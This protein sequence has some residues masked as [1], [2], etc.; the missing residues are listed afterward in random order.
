[1]STSLMRLKAE[2]DMKRGIG[3]KLWVQTDILDF[4]EIIV[5]RTQVGEIFA[6]LVEP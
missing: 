2:R 3:G 6:T 5:V 4:L 1:M